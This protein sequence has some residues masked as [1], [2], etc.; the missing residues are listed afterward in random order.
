[1]QRCCQLSQP[2]SMCREPWTTRV[3][4]ALRQ[5]YAMLP[6]LYTLFREANT[7]GVPV[8]RP[9]W[10]VSAAELGS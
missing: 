3:R 10:C 1:M 4:A 2:A 5:R 9:I 7:D 8:M 6:Y